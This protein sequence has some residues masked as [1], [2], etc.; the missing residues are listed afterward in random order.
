[1][2]LTNE[3]KL[4]ILRADCKKL[5]DWIRD[6]FEHYAEIVITADEIR[7]NENLNKSINKE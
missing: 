3:Q 4:S 7:L 1:M 5:S 2:K 6:N